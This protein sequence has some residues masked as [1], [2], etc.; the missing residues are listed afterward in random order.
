VCTCASAANWPTFAITFRNVEVYIDPIDY[1]ATVGSGLCTYNFGS[2][3]GISELLLGDI[4]F[5][6]YI[7]TFDKLNNQVGFA[8]DSI[9][10]VDNSS[11]SDIDEVLGW[12]L[13][14]TVGLV[15]LIGLIACCCI[16]SSI[17]GIV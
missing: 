16:E 11:F 14:G 12:I 10:P 6:N 8:G 7:I 15:I 1:T 5:R 13:M 17:T 9:V 4:F 2:I 3:S